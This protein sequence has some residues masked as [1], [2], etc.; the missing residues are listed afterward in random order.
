MLTGGAPLR[1]A[2]APRGTA[3]CSAPIDVRAALAAAAVRSVGGFVPYVRPKN[4]SGMTEVKIKFQEELHMGPSRL[5]VDPRGKTVKTKSKNRFPPCFSL[6]FR[7]KTLQFD[8]AR[9]EEFVAPG[10]APET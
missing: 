7:L 4:Q 5:Y 9:R 8:R 2:P 1:L 10:R 3:V 6:F